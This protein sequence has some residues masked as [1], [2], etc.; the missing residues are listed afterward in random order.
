V[1]LSGLGGV[2][3][4]LAGEPVEG[5]RRCGGDRGGLP[6]QR[7]GPADPR[8]PARHGTHLLR[9]LTVTQYGRMFR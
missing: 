2:L 9:H 3:R 7:G 6:V 5:G 4:G 1:V 8:P